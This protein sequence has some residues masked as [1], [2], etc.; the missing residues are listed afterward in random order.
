[1]L[2][3][4]AL[5]ALLLSTSFTAALNPDCAPGGNFDLSIWELQLP[6]GSTGDPTTISNTELEGC[7]GWENFS[8]FFT[9]T[10]DGALVMKCLVLRRVLAV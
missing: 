2:K 10:G 3:T 5:V 9:E 7:D 8:Y 6:I 4:Q 1:M